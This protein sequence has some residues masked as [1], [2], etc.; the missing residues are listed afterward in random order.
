MENSF[1]QD[2]TFNEKKRQENFQI[3]SKK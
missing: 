2:K 1:Y 3:E